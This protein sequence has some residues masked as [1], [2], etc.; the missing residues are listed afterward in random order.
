VAHRVEQVI[1]RALPGQVMKA[2]PRL[3]KY[4]LEGATRAVG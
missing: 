3:R 2:G 4:S 1:G